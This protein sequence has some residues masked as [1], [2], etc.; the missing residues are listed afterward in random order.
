MKVL[1]KVRRQV[2]FF[3]RFILIKSCEMHWEIEINPKFSI[4][5][6]L[7]FMSYFGY[8]LL[9][10]IIQRADIGLHDCEP[11]RLYGVITQ[12][13]TSSARNFV[14]SAILLHIE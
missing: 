5:G 4:K 7:V 8:S 14:C 2:F 3:V 12:K 13:R 11:C 1:Q 9:V 6:Q 10:L